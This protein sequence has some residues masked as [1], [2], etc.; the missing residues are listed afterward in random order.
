MAPFQNLFTTTTE[1]RKH[2]PREVA[3]STFHR[4]IK[5]HPGLALRLGG[6][7]LPV[8]AAVDAIGR[9]VSLADAA[10]IGADA[11]KAMTDGRAAA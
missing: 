5:R 8:V 2:L 9:G 7:D 3:R 11:I 1:A 4:W 6:R 10:R